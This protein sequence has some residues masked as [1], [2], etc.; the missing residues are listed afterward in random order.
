MLSS[1]VVYCTKHYKVLDMYDEPF[2]MFC[3]FNIKD[4]YYKLHPQR[5]GTPLVLIKFSYL[6][7]WPQNLLVWKMFP[8]GAFVSRTKMIGFILAYISICSQRFCPKCP[9][10]TS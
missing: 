1:K 7:K 4:L 8:C 5:A 6:W 9:T 10:R 2:M 3:N